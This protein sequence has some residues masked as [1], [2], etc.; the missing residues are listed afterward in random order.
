MEENLKMPESFAREVGDGRDWE[1]FVAPLKTIL[2]ILSV[3]KAVIL[4]LGILLCFLLSFLSLSNG[5]I[6]SAVSG[7]ITLALIFGGLVFLCYVGELRCRAQIHQ[8]ALEFQ[9]RNLLKQIAKKDKAEG[10]KATEAA[11]KDSH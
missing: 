7:T 3:A 4:V 5:T 11:D 2:K 1:E 8:L 10:V 6:A 9:Q